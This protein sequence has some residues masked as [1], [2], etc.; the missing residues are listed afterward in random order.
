MNQKAD[1]KFGVTFALIAIIIVGL[2]IVFNSYVIV[3]AGHV[4]VVKHFGA[5]DESPLPEGLHFIVP[6][7][8]SVEQ[9]DIRLTRA[10]EAAASASKDLQTVK[11]QVTVQFSLSGDKTPYIVQK[12]GNLEVAKATL[13]SPAIQESVKAITAK[14]TAE[15][16]VTRRAEV[17]LEIQ[18]S[19]QNFIEITLT[20]KELN[21]ALNIANVA[22]TD[23]D[24]SAEFNR[25]IELKVKAE[26]EALQAKN[27]KSRRVT[28]AEAAAE[29]KKLAAQASAYEIEMSSKA[30]ANA[31]EIEAKALK[32]NPQLIKL[33]MI[34]K[35]NGV[36]PKINTGSTGTLLEIDAGLLKE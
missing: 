9:V 28:Q 11:T 13:I 25:A 14:Y 17:K 26:Q 7:R 12:M 18:S 35:W 1:V 15:E 33:R 31:I 30:R 29:E 20:K 23:F 4:G 16:L 10:T 6:I 2:S 19:L 36:L 3:E 34:E 5:I 27:E 21:N 24:F 8:D 32:D 22:I